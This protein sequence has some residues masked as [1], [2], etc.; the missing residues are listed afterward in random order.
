MDPGEITRPWYLLQHLVV[1]IEHFLELFAGG[2]SD[3]AGR[4]LFL[5]QRIGVEVTTLQD[6]HQRT[7]PNHQQSCR[8]LRQADK[9]FRTVAEAQHKTS[10]S[11]LAAVC[12]YCW[13]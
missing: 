8:M 2:V 13:Q 4:C 9:H 5:V 7:N 3:V 6:Y 11:S 12:V 1:P 10:F